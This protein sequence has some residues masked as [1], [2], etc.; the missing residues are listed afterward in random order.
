MEKT[1]WIGT[2]SAVG[3][4]F[5]DDDFTTVFRNA[6]PTMVDV[7]QGQYRGFGGD[8]MRPIQSLREQGTG[9]AQSK[10]HLIKILMFVADVRRY[11]C[12]SQ[13]EIPPEI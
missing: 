3:G 5:S 11:E 12:K 1:E 4:E 10:N 6:R 9:T 2:W 8:H 7:S 13:F